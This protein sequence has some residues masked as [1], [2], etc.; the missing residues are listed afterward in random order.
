MQV[1]NVYDNQCSSLDVLLCLVT[2]LTINI[3][4]S[5]QVQHSQPFTLAMWEQFKELTSKDHDAIQMPIQIRANILIVEETL[6]WFV[7]LFNLM[8]LLNIQIG[9]ITWFTTW[10][11]IMVASS[12]I[13]LHMIYLQEHKITFHHRLGKG[14][15]CMD[16]LTLLSQRAQCPQLG[17]ESNKTW[18][19]NITRN[20]IWRKHVF[21]Q[22]HWWLWW[23]SPK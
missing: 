9:L 23:G 8:F 7:I 20:G 18:A 2:L 15:K 3:D 19:I 12:Y 5:C 11:T 13:W 4:V 17:E 10:N 16:N 21:W 1:K 6:D 22:Q 14:Q